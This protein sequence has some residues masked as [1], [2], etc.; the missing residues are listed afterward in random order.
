MFVQLTL[1]AL[2]TCT[3]EFLIE[4]RSRLISGSF[5]NVIAILNMSVFVSLTLFDM[6]KTVYLSIVRRC[7]MCKMVKVKKWRIKEYKKEQE[8]KQQQA[9]AKAETES[10]KR[11][12]EAKQRA[13]DKAK[14]DQLYKVIGLPV[15]LP[16]DSESESDQSSQQLDSIQEV[17]DQAE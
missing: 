17:S 2:L 4:D 6:F 7:N 5:I 16:S 9:L 10:L 14:Q 11:K 15:V 3:G 1:F 8:D 12:K 13:I